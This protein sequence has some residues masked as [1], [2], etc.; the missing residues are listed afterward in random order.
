MGQ[1][2]GIITNNAGNPLQGALVE[3]KDSNNTTVDTDT[4]DSGGNWFFNDPNTDT[5]GYYVQVTKAGYGDVIFPSTNPP[6]M[7]PM[8]QTTP[9][10]TSQVPVWVWIAIGIVALGVII[11]ISKYSKKLK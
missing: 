10:V 9:V 11:A 3:L 2:N 5:E 7:I 1:I 4:T 6:S 8:Y